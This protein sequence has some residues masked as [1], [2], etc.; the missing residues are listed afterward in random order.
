[1][2][3]TVI[4]ENVDR[5]AQRF[6]QERL[7]RQQ[8]TTLHQEDFAALKTAGFPL[9]AVPVEQGGAF[10][11][12]ASSVRPLC[13]ILRALGRG[14]SS[15]A[16]VCAMHPAVMS[17]WLAFSN[18]A[19]TSQAAWQAQRESLFRHIRDGAFI[20]TIPSEPGS[21]GDI[22]QTRTVAWRCDSGYVID[23]QKHFG[24]GFGIV[25]FMLTSALP[26]GEPEPDWFM[27]DVRGVPA[28]GSR[29]LTLTAPWDGHGMVATQSHALLFTG[30]PAER[31]AWPGQRKQIQSAAGPF[32]GCL[33]A[34]VIA[35]VVD[36][37]IAI[38][39]SQLAPRHARLRP[40][41]QVEWA[42]A[43]IDA[44]LV[45]QALDGMLRAV[46]HTPPRERE[47]TQGKLAIAELAESCL[48][49]LCR[50][51]GGSSYSRRSPI[52]Q[53]FEDVRALGFLRPPW[54]LAYD[55]LLACDP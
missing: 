27:L 25:S 39:H 50:V 17:Q 24:S 6:A 49:R 2:D 3:Y 26:E 19:E 1:M 54:G 15:V 16:L 45:S 33:F 47:V 13:G 40:F 34:A 46:E 52:G 55:N 20:G 30:F 4:R 36:A 9:V 37:A 43:E 14:D 11:S 38:A 51:L 21:G 22:A 23:G 41:E 28:D 5:L 10:G 29:G 31:C 18:V 53:L 7:V 32:V 42:R 8:R 35:G 48:Q 12:L 44:W